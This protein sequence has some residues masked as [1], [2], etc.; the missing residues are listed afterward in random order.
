MWNAIGMRQMPF[1]LQGNLGMDEFELLPWR[2]E[3][4]ISL[5]NDP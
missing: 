2:E 1:R 3:E 4:M 5:Q